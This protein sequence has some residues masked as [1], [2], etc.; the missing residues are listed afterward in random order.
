MRIQTASDTLVGFTF[1]LSASAL[2][3]LNFASLLVEASEV[4]EAFAYGREFSRKSTSG[5][6]HG[7]EV[8]IVN[9]FEGSEILFPIEGTGRETKTSGV[10][11]LRGS[12][13]G[14]GIVGIGVGDPCGKLAG[15]L[16][17]IEA[18][19]EQGGWVDPGGEAQVSQRIRASHEASRRIQDRF[20][21]R[22]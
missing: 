4:S 18:M 19:S 21:S 2:C 1:D 6:P 9:L 22:A 13:T 8:T 16:H 5:G 20:R 15:R 11:D 10:G 7:Q 12:N 3:F 14:R 17:G